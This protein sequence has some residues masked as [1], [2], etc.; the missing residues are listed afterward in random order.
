MK[1][2]GKLIHLNSAKIDEICKHKGTTRIAWAEHLANQAKYPN[3]RIDKEKYILSKKIAAIAIKCVPTFTN[4]TLEYCSDVKHYYK[5]Y[6]TKSEW[7]A[8]LDSLNEQEK[9][10]IDI[11]FNNLFKI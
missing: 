10:Q 9:K 8:F 5:S 6:G 2:I 11:E 1:N 4:T 3:N 7:Y